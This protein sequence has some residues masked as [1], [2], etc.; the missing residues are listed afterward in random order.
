MFGLLKSVAGLALDVV[1]VVATPVEIMVDVASAAI[2]PVAE[3]AR[4]LKN[5]VKNLKD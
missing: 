4:D 2:K 3:V 5:E 1:E